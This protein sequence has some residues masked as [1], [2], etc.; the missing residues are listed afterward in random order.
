MSTKPL[1]TQVLVK[2]WYISNN[3]HPDHVYRACT[4]N[5]PLDFVQLAALIP[6]K[7]DN[8]SITTGDNFICLIEL[9]LFLDVKREMNKKP[10]HVHNPF[11]GPRIVCG[12][13]HGTYGTDKTGPKHEHDI[14]PDS[15][16]DNI[17]VNESLC[18]VGELVRI[19]A[20]ENPMSIHQTALTS[21]RNDSLNSE[22]MYGQ[23]R[24]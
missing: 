8:K 19:L 23:T 7:D 17:T 3:P 2:F 14:P 15:D 12:G 13:G 5:L 4:A 11:D 16:L 6:K 20:R 10:P 18:P 1:N 9:L 22:D 24:Y 21:I